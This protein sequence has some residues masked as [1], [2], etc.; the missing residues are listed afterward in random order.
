MN[1][2]EAKARLLAI[3]TRHVGEEK[4]IGMGELYSQVF[5]E[6]WSHRINDT[7]KLRRLITELRYDGSLIGET[8]AKT[9]GG[10][11]LARSVFEMG[12]FVRRRKREALRK[13]AMI[14]AMQRIGLPELL[15]QMQLNLQPERTDN[16]GNRTG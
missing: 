12:E 7:R 15:G 8:R 14:A 5:G 4:A 10:Y 9:G 11:Y 2:D 1:K 13:L 16:A 3:L 6:P